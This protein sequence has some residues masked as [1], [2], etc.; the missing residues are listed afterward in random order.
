MQ[1]M[2]RTLKGTIPRRLGCNP[3]RLRVRRPHRA[4]SALSEHQPRASQ[5]WR[6]VLF[7]LRL[8]FA[9]LALFVIL[10]ERVDGRRL[11][12]HVIDHE[13]HAEIIEAVA[14]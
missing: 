14:P 3:V 7:L 6:I 2:L 9:C 12:A 5:N 11:L 10:L 13:G 4:A 1:D 8:D